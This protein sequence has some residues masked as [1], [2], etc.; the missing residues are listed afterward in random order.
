[1]WSDLSA[2]QKYELMRATGINDP[3]RLKREY[4]SYLDNI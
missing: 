1:M 2:L 4:D 3:I